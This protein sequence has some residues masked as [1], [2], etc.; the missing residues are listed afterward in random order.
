[1]PIQKTYLR[2]VPAFPPAVIEEG[3]LAVID[4]ED[5]PLSRGE[6]IQ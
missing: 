6:L 3:R 2:K 5:E 1:L 4:S